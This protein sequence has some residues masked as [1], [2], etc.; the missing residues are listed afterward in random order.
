MG[1]KVIQRLPLARKLYRDFFNYF[2][3]SA[4]MREL[5]AICA[6]VRSLEADSGTKGRCL[7]GWGR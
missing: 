1:N 6:R 3:R 5:T 4:L 2:V 7:G